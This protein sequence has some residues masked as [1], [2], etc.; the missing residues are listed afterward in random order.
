MEGRDCS[1]V[2][3]R[4]TRFSEDA[5]ADAN[6]D[7]DDVVTLYGATK[8]T[9]AIHAKLRPHS[10]DEAVDP[11]SVEVSELGLP[12]VSRIILK[13]LKFIRFIS[14]I[15]LTRIRKRRQNN[16]MFLMLNLLNLTFSL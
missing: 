2:E 12:E 7:E 5:A 16:S 13:K 3:I 1:G 10:E 4:E 15:V 14:G 11:A 6:G 8:N 9:T